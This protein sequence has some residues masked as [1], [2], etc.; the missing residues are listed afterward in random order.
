MFLQNFDLNC[1][2]SLLRTGDL[3]GLLGHS[4]T[5]IFMYNVYDMDYRYYLSYLFILFKQNSV[6][7]TIGTLEVPSVILSGANR[8][9]ELGHS[10]P[11][12]FGGST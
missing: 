2:R 3:L 9:P 11:M 12:C 7:N 8:F 5:Y 4:H 10:H 1:A 6:K